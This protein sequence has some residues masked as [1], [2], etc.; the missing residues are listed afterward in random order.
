MAR[1][2]KNASVGLQA[3]NRALYGSADNWQL[4]CRSRV[5]SDL[6]ARNDL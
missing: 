2:M 6:A 3:A 5:R 4:P 1:A